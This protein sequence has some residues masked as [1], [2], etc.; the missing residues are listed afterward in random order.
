MNVR[1]VLFGDVKELRNA[2]DVE[3]LE[4]SEKF[5]TDYFRANRGLRCRKER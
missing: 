1:E 5:V 3:E 2:P 4:R